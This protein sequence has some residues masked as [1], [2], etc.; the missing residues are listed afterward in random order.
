M[1][2]IRQRSSPRRTPRVCIVCEAAHKGEVERFVGAFLNG[3]PAA[4]KKNYFERGFVRKYA[5]KGVETEFFTTPDG[6]P[7]SY[8]HACEQAIERASSIQQKWDLALVQIEESFH[9]L[10][11]ERNPYYV[12]KVAFLTHQIPVQEFEIETAAASGTQ[13]SAVLN[14]MALAVMRNLAGFLGSSRRIPRL[15]MNLW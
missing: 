1:V 6:T 3:V 7:A 4:G 13:L 2:R 9:R 12:A 5:I 11:A 15:R 8:L 14:N 10:P